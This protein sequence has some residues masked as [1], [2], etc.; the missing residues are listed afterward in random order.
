MCVMSG[1]RRG[2]LVHTGL[3][4]SSGVVLATAHRELVI[5]NRL[6]QTLLYYHLK[7]SLATAWLEWVFPDGGITCVWIVASR[8]VRH[9]VSQHVAVSEW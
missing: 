8:D 9:Q 4:C 1:I 6:E 3:D 7:P 5:Y 2:L